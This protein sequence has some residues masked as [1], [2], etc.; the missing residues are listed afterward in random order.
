[1]ALLILAALFVPPALAF[2][3]L[4]PLPVLVLAE[5]GVLLAAGWWF[6][7]GRSIGARDP[8]L[9]GNRPEFPIQFGAEVRPQ[10]TEVIEKP[11]D[12]PGAL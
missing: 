11:K 12:R 7:H 4:V 10:P 6:D 9:D 5:I 8:F 1:M 3:G 2:L